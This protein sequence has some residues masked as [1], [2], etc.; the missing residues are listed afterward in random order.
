MVKEPLDPQ[1]TD[2]GKPAEGTQEP[3][4]GIPESEKGLGTQ[5]TNAQQDAEGQPTSNP[6]KP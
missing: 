5:G 4:G 1:R 2:E 3:M 6:I